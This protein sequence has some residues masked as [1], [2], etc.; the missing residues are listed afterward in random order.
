MGCCRNKFLITEEDRRHILSL[1][2]LITEEDTENVKTF[3]LGNQFDPG[4]WNSLT[5]GSTVDLKSKMAE[6][7]TWLE[8]KKGT[9]QFVVIQ[10]VASESQVPNYDREQ[11]GDIK[12][13]PGYLSRLRAKTMKRILTTYFQDL[14]NKKLISEIPVFEEPKLEINGPA[15]KRD[16]PKNYN[17]YQFVK[18]IMK[19]MSPAGCLSEVSIQV[20]YYKTPDAKFPCRGGHTCNKASFDI[21]M[22]DVKVGEAN[23]NNAND[24]GDRVSP[25]ITI[26]IDKAQEIVKNYS[27][28][29]RTITIAT[30]CKIGSAADCHSGA[31]EVL[32]K[33]GGEILYNAC[34]PALSEKGDLRDIPLLKIDPCGNVLVKGAGT[35]SNSESPQGSGSATTAATPSSYTLVLPSDMM[36]GIKGKV[37]E[38]VDTK[39]LIPEKT[40]W[41]SLA[42]TDDDGKTVLAYNT[43]FTVGTYGLPYTTIVEN[44]QRQTGKNKVID[45]DPGTKLSSI[46]NSRVTTGT[47]KGKTVDLSQYNKNP[48]PGFKQEGL[49]GQECTNSK[50]Y[51]SEARSYRNPGEPAV[52][53]ALL[54][55]GCESV[56]KEQAKIEAE[57]KKKGIIK[58]KLDD[59]DTLQSFED[60]YVKNKLVEKQPNGD[61]KVIATYNPKTGYSIAYGGETFQPSNF[62]RFV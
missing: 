1:Y 37:K 45:V 61:Y 8:E 55:A 19:V 38:W 53:G 46:I 18:V 58:I 21:M 32:I 50:K 35:G 12:V 6:L 36:G 56:K 54:V 25:L 41:A 24:G 2:N 16:D 39:C 31:P 51:E 40:N 47:V 4:K 59:G 27:S 34:S 57:D 49:V 13:D 44:P 33:K 29:N 62:I 17:E 23:L 7:G 20:A 3:E 10:I 30:R 22:N 11:S 14:V 5:T 28:S 9:G 60:F 43:T 52:E 48:L 15:W 26:P 42:I